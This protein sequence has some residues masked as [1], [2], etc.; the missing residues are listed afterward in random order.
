M[1]SAPLPKPSTTGR[2]SRLPQ[3]G[4]GT[5]GIEGFKQLSST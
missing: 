3:R 1:T 4:E 2:A 5:I